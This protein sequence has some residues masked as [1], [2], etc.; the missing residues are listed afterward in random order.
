M[1]RIARALELGVSYIGISVLLVLITVTNSPATSRAATT[2]PSTLSTYCTSPQILG[3]VLTPPMLYTPWNQP[4]LSAFKDQYLPTVTVTGLPEGITLVE[5]DATI[6]DVGAP[7]HMWMLTGTPIQLGTYSVTVTAQNSCGGKVVTIP[8]QIT[9]PVNAPTTGTSVLPTTSQCP[10]G[11]EGAY[12]NCYV[13]NVGPSV[14]FDEGSLASNSATATVTG[15]A[16][17]STSVYLQV[18]AP[19]GL[20]YNTNPTNVVGGQWSITLT[21]LKSGLYNLFLYD[22]NNTPLIPGV[23]NVTLSSTV[24]PAVTSPAAPA[25]PSTQSVPSMPV[26][27]TAPTNTACSVSRNVSFGSRGDDVIAL[28]MILI[29]KG[30]LSSDSATGY[31]GAMTRTAVRQF[32]TEQGIVSAGDENST[33]YG[34]V[35]VRTRAALGIVCSTSAQTSANTPPVT[36]TPTPVVIPVIPATPPE[37][38]PTYPRSM[39]YVE[40]LTS[41]PSCPKVTVPAC[42][43]GIITSLGTD[44]NHCA[45]GYSCKSGGPVCPAIGMPTCT[46]G[47]PISKG[48]DANGCSLGYACQKVTCPMV[49]IPTSC[50][51]GQ[52][53]VSA[54]DTYGCVTYSAC[55]NN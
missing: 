10:V 22:N 49:Q 54:T 30:L 38:D 43:G 2:T 25:L 21:G 6:A 12:P 32:Q 39:F 31:F 3:S 18:Q 24:V 53:L 51:V 36:T 1:H 47:Y 44:S 42:P 28:Q 4:L 34:L 48:F 41:L 52:H 55:Q 37:L 50:P 7:L 40:P 27:P 33:G 46:G 20:T 15:K 16:R 8:L 19:G 45:L 17:T 29:Q 35:G 26:F 5:Q 11:T 13:L 14:A 9:S 23:L